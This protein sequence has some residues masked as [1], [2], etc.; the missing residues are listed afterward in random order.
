V[1]ARRAIAFLLALSASVLF[2]AAARAELPD[3][4]TNTVNVGPIT[5]GGVVGQGVAAYDPAGTQASADSRVSLAGPIP[6]VAGGGSDYTYRP[7]PYNQLPPTP[8]LVANN[9]GTTSVPQGGAQSACPPGQT[10][11]LVYGSGGSNSFGVICVPAGQAVTSPEQ[12]LAQLA[13]SSQPWPN[14]VLDVNPG[15]GLTGLGSWF[16]LGGASTSMPD[17]TASSG[18]LTVR[19]HAAVAGATWDFGDGSRYYS[20]GL[21]QAYPAQSDVEHV[22]QTDTYGLPQGYTVSGMLRFL[23]TYSVNGGPWQQ[24]GVKVRAYS[25]SYSVFQLQPVAVGGQ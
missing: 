14:L 19:V 2:P 20:S 1:A 15:S 8:S 9:S 5:S 22:Y 24:L 4:G 10:G 17:A 18:P 21:G 25:R 23:V 13:S 7:V 6:A 12:Q 11:Y 3:P 16:W